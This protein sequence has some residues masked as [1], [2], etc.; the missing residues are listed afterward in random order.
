MFIQ[1]TLAYLF[2]LVVLFAGANITYG[3]LTKEED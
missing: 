2:G 3:I 1:A